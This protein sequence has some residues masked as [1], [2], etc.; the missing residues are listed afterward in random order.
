[1]IIKPQ[2]IY[3]GFQNSISISIQEFK[4]KLIGYKIDY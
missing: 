4:P 3:F 1:M 2:R